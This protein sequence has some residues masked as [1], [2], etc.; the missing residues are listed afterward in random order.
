VTGGWYTLYVVKATG[1]S[2]LLEPK[3]YAPTVD[4]KVKDESGNWVSANSA[5]IG[6]DVE[7][8]ITATV[9]SRILEYGTYYVNISDTMS[10]G[11]T[12]KNVE[13][14]VKVTMETTVTETV[15]GQ[16]VNE[17]LTEDVTKYFY[18]NVGEPSETD[19]TTELTVAIQ[20]LKALQNVKENNAAKY[21]VNDTTKLIVTYTAVLNENAVVIDPSTNEVHMDYYNDPNN[22]GKGTADPPDET[23]DKPEPKYPT[24]ETIKSVT[25]TYTTSITILKENDN[26]Q[27]LT[28]AE[29]TLT[30]DNVYK[31][32][33]S[34]A[35]TFTE[36]EKGDYWKLV[37]GAYTTDAPDMDSEEN[38]K[39][40]DST[41]QKYSR[42]VET[43][44]IAVAENGKSITGAVDENGLLSFTGLGAG[45]YTLSETKTPAG[46]NTMTPLTFEITFDGAKKQFASNRGYMET[47]DGLTFTTIIL[48]HAGSTLPQTGG[49]GTT[50]FYVVGTVMILGAAVLLVVKKRMSR[51]GD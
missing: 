12:F 4:K 26:Y 29:F 49:I 48:N 1:G 13:N 9:N 11:L 15:D 6:E 33:V 37:S 47:D 2:I 46:Y 39:L 16:L 34:T 7:Y 24:G 44:L 22:S 42:T 28:G 20:D 3:G 30:G 50:I 40:Y 36:D 10:K 38:V 23:P 31:M 14:N 27:V 8:K 19:G 25:E 43:K 35:F 18:I 17:T 51:E 5:S 45:T 21:V 41:T 32:K